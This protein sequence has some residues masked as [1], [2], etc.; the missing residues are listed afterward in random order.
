MALPGLA[1]S[2]SGDTMIAVGFVNSADLLL[3]L[4]KEFDL[5]THYSAP[6]TDFFYR[7][8]PAAP[9]EDRLEYYRQRINAHFD[10]ESGLVLFSVDAYDPQYAYR[11]ATSVLEKA[12]LFVNE[13]NQKVADQQLAFFR[14]EVERTSS[15]VEE[16]NQ[17]LVKLQNQHNFI[18][19]DEMIS[20]SLAAVQ[21][22]K[23]E[24]LRGEAELSSMERDS[25]GSPRIENLRSRIRS[26]NELIAVESAKL[27]GPEQDRLNQILLE[28]KRLQQ[29]LE[30]AIQLRGSALTMLEKNRIDAIAQ[31][32]FFSVI[33]NPFTPE[34]VGKP[35][36]KY[37]TATILVIG[38]LLFVVLRSLAQSVMDR[39]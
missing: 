14:G 10:K 9:V 24:L 12:E 23:M 21:E 36:R 11:V 19:P 34:R 5:V 18:N 8:D 13:L 28:F 15:H 31:S 39:R 38:L 4:E 26:L 35:D 37:A 16:L 27:S 7:L 33:Q 2:S 6:K 20:A 25:P 1:E 29:K 32:R 22:M 30:F 3:Q 17:E